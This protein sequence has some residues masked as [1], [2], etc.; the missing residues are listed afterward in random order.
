MVDLMA[1]QALMGQNLDEEWASAQ[2]RKGFDS[3]DVCNATAKQRGSFARL[4]QRKP[5]KQNIWK[6]R[7][8][9]AGFRFACNQKSSRQIIQINRS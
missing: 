4:L 3:I 6:T 9:P 7:R 2:L 8:F 5:L 1:F